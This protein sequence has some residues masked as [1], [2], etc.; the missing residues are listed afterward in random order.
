MKAL[1]GAAKNENESVVRLLLEKCAGT[2][3]TYALQQAAVMGL[4]GSGEVAAR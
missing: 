1:W 3:D 4:R 2:K